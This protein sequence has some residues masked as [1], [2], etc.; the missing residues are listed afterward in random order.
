M[1]QL[2]IPQRKSLDAKIKKIV[3]RGDLNKEQIIIFI[4]IFQA[5]ALSRIEATEDTILT[6]LPDDDGNAVSNSREIF[7]GNTLQTL[8]KYKLYDKSKPFPITWYELSIKDLA[9]KLIFF[10][11]F[12]FSNA[13]IFGQ[14]FVRVGAAKTSTNNRAITLGINYAKPMDSSL[15]TRDFIVAGKHSYFMF[16][17]SLAINAGTEDAQSSILFQLNGLLVYH[18]DTTLTLLVPTG[19]ASVYN[20]AFKTYSRNASV[21]YD[22]VKITTPDPYRTMHTV[23]ISGGIETTTL[24]NVINGIVEIGYV[25]HYQSS[26]NDLVR[27]TKLFLGLQGGYKFWAST[28]VVPQTGGLKNESSEA[29][30]SWIARAKGS[31]GF[32]SKKMFTLQGLDMGVVGTSTVWYDLRNSRFYHVIEGALRTY[33]TD[34]KYFDMLYHKGSGPPTFNLSDQ[35]GVALTVKLWIFI[36]IPAYKRRKYVACAA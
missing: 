16:T 26:T 35:W 34:T 13:A 20:P 22:T 18:H 28:T 7:K 5:Q 4:M 27:H 21:K 29:V 32:D 24:F 11:I 8:M 19:Q 15:K 31:F 6:V 23:T 12:L 17:P 9:H 30:R 33:L 25:P 36:L 10:F 2:T 1:K 14:N 3:R